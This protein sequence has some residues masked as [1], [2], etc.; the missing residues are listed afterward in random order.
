MRNVVK[1]EVL[2]PESGSSESGDTFVVIKTDMVERRL[3]LTHIDSLAFDSDDR[4]KPTLPEVVTN[5]GLMF[6]K[7]P[8][9]IDQSVWDDI[10]KDGDRVITMEKEDWLK[11]W[12]NR[13]PKPGRL[14]DMTHDI[15]AQ[16]KKMKD[17][18]AQF[19]QKDGDVDVEAVFTRLQLSV[20][21]WA[22][23]VN[24]TVA[25]GAMLQFSQDAQKARQGF[26]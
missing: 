12:P 14:K 4:G 17:R 13:M 10:F 5:R 8:E 15:I 18:F 3:R 1:V 25:V 20:I 11:D 6:S 23:I 22:V 26:T 7:N 9:Y 16:Q 21:R 19:A 24:V 2:E